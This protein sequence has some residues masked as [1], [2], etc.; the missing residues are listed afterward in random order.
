MFKHLLVPIDG[1]PAALQA[2]KVAARFAREQK[3]SLT[4]LWVAPDWEP[5][6]YAYADAVPAGYV[7]PQQHS[8]HIRK[9][10]KR[11]L[12]AAKKTAA[13]AGA[14][15]RGV[16]VEGSIPYLEIIKA[17]RRHRCD[18]IVMAPHTQGISR[19]L[20]SQTAKVLAH[21]EVPVMVMK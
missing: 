9:A 3:A 5:D 1:S 16:Y 10:A 11:Y 12:A 6:L 17:A 2:V 4:A 18:L 7:S 20:G 15:C 19:L 21:A 13:A 8:A 14:P